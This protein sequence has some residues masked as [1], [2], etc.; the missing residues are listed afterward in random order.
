MKEM[1]KNRYYNWKNSFS[2]QILISPFL[3]KKNWFI[4]NLS[5]IPWAESKLPM[6]LAERQPLSAFRGLWKPVP[7]ISHTGG[8]RAPDGL[9][10]VYA[11]IPKVKKS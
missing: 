7:T 10:V 2:F 8:K 5:R 3:Q 1:D 9:L 11:W 6:P 4:I